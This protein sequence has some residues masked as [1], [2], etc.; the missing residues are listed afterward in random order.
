MDEPKIT[1]EMTLKEYDEQKERADRYRDSIDHLS[2]LDS[3][4]FRPICEILEEDFSLNKLNKIINAMEEGRFKANIVDLG[5][6][7]YEITLK[8]KVKI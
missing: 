8:K 5:N 4:F 2:R 1:I 3:V 7:E 6:G